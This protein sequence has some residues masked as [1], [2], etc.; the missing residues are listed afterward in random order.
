[1]EILTVAKWWKLDPGVVERWT[2][3]DFTDRQE[4]MYIQFELDREDEDD[5]PEG[6]LWG[7]PES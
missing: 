1:M 6:K 5:E 4:Y 2:M 7:G 3:P